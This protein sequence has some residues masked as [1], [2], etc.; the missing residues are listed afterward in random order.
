[1]RAAQAVAEWHVLP[2]LE[3]EQTYA[4]Q[5]YRGVESRFVGIGNVFLKKLSESGVPEFARMPNALDSDK[6]FRSPSRFTFERLLRVSLP[7]SPLRY[8]AD[9]VLGAVGASFA[10][11]RDAREFLDHL[12]ETNSARVQSDVV[13]RVQESRGQLEVEI[14]KL[15]HEVSRIAERA[16]EHARAAKAE[17]VSTVESALSRLRRIE[18]ELRSMM[19]E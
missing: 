1:M 17:G 11:E 8:I 12:M 2:W 18:E 6:G 14:R 7:A 5:Q 16:L 3:A 13:N 19:E 9:V 4:E 15:L 10:I